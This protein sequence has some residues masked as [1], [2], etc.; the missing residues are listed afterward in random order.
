MPASGVVITGAGIVSPLGLDREKT[1]AAVLEGRCGITRLTAID[2]E[3][4]EDRDGGEAPALPDDFEPNLPREARYLRKA[5]LDALG[6]SG[7]RA[8]GRIAG[9]RCGIIIGTTLHGMRAAGEFLRSND[10]GHLSRFLASHVVEAAASDLGFD[11]FAATTCSACSSS[12]GSIALGVTMLESGEFDV[13]IAGG[14]DPIS[15]YAYA[16][17][18]SLRL[19]A[20]GPLRPFAR[21]REGMK[22]SEGYGIVIL[23]R[24]KGAADRGARPLAQIAGFGESADAHHLTQ[25]HPE[26]EGAARAMQQAIASSGLRPG[27]INLLV[28]HATGTPDNDASEYAAMSRVFGE[29]LPQI[30]CVAF[31]SHLGHTLGGAGAVELILAAMA[32]QRQMIPPCA[33]VTSDELQYPG[34]NLV[35]GTAR[36]AK[37][38]ALMSTSLG[39][40]GA[41]TCVV[42]TPPGSAAQA[43]AVHIRQD[44]SR[45]VLITGIGVV[46]PGAIGNEQFLALLS[47]PQPAI[48]EGVEPLTE[49]AIAPHLVNARRARRLS[50]YVKLMLAATSLA[51]ADAGV[52]D[53]A[54]F[55][56]GCSA[57][58]G[59]T[60]GST[61]YSESYYRQVVEEGVL[62]ANPMLFAEGVPNAGSAHV[63]LML[64]IKG[65]CQ[66]IIGSRTAGLDAL[67]LAMRRIQ[68]GRWD[69][70]IVGAA[71]EPSA[72]MHGV[73]TKCGLGADSPACMPFET[74][75][76]FVS[77]SGSVV[78][79]ME[80]RASAQR[81]SAR[82]RG[83]VSR[84][85]TRWGNKQFAARAVSELLE[86]I[87]APRAIMSSANA[88]WI[89]AHELAGIRHFAAGR[90]ISPA[91]S[92]MYGHLAETFSVMPLAGIA[93]GLLSGRLPR[94]WS[95]ADVTNADGEADEFAVLCSDYRGVCS[96]ASVRR[97]SGA[98]R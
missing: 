38:R 16:G 56:S 36:P 62:A 54:A 24:A 31:K 96:A 89:D 88:T 67:S 68:T 2:C 78:L 46:L 76:G 83:I 22:V 39:F 75:G 13:I 19:V 6:E 21:D 64:G 26:G 61:S 1:F 37:I 42:L 66:T 18:N 23:E 8:D 82:A 70:A 95:S 5:I 94:L 52:E 74:P 33:N 84:V 9:K 44:N 11:R 72:L 58:L 80:S 12:L 17:F 7:L 77:S 50:E 25:P 86:E 47:R 81:R 15:E 49:D 43:P 69:K 4:P 98:D 79:V 59:T 55:A 30:P 20:G 14:Y 93:A 3:L 85:S 34:L 51:L 45:D 40:G 73:Y 71:E 32:M 27:E 92:S 29:A 60:H 28:A 41:N 53:V 90:E 65:A 97:I 57:I 87:E 35:T 48:R 91:I 10:A 63:S